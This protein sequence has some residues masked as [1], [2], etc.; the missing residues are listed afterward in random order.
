MQKRRLAADA[1]ATTC[2]CAQLPSYAKFR[3]LQAGW[4]SLAGRGG[5]TRRSGASARCG[6]SIAAGDVCWSPAPE[7]AATGFAAG[8]RSAP[9][10]FAAI[11]SHCAWAA[12]L[13]DAIGIFAA[14]VTQDCFALLSAVFTFALLVV[15]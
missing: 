6:R 11:L 8:G 12:C 5:L 13:S 15:I 2:T 9:G 14:A 3:T 7:A 10:Y 4:G 1:R